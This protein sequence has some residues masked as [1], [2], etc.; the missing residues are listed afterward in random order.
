MSADAE[1]DQQFSQILF[2]RQI[3]PILEEF[4]DAKIIPV[5]GEDTT[6]SL[7]LD[8][9]SGIDYAV[10]VD[11]NVMGISNRVQYNKNWQTFTVRSR[12][13]N[14]YH[15]ELYKRYHA[16]FKGYFAPHLVCQSYFQRNPYGLRTLEE[17][18]I[19]NIL[20]FAIARDVDIIEIAASNVATDKHTRDH[21]VGQAGFKVINWG[22]IISLRC[23]ILQ[24]SPIDGFTGFV[25]GHK[26]PK[27]QII[28][29]LFNRMIRPRLKLLNTT[30][31]IDHSI[32]EFNIAEGVSS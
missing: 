21:C 9:R 27:S 6:L 25:N 22:D 10:V 13:D 32:Y 20:G 31:R 17:F 16:R 14:G 18:D 11:S 29:G 8:Q 30:S 7:A 2:Q 12:R 26:V 24:Y 19:I 4:F 1:R 28:A 15:S 5:E 23:P 3:K